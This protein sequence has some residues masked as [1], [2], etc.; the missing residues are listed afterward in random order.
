M[1]VHVVCHLE[2]ALLNENRQVLR[3]V[4]D[5]LGKVPPV[6]D[7]YAFP[8]PPYAL[9]CPARS[10]TSL[11]FARFCVWYLIALEKSPSERYAI[12]SM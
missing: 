1:G 7:L 6:S 11:A 10:P 5:P 8:R 2:P 12:P 9:P 4:R 3:V